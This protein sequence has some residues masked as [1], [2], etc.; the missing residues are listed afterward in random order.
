MAVQIQSLASDVPSLNLMVYADSGAGKTVF[1]GSAKR[2]LFVA[3]EDD[4][5]LS[6]VRMGSQA[7]KIKVRTWEDF[8]EGYEYCYDNQDEL[9]E[10][11][12]W[13][14]I[15][16][17][18]EMQ[19]MCLRSIVNSQRAERIS[20]DQDPDQPQIQDYGKLYILMEKMILAFNDLPINVLWTA[21]ARKAEDPDGNDFLL[22]MLG[23]NKPTDYRI[24]MKVAAQMTSYGY[25][26]V[27]VVDKPAPTDDDPK[28]TRKVKQRTI[29][30]EDTGSTRGKDRTTRLQPKTTLPARNALEYITGLAN[31]LIERD[32]TPVGKPASDV[33]APRKAAKKAAPQPKVD[34]K[35]TNG[36]ETGDEPK[37]V[38]LAS[39]EA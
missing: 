30:W 33:N 34:E 23:S 13:I 17:A 26:K 28:R 37:S 35:K 15:D 11:Y 22:P 25:L 16:S 31:G 36:E 1:A 27:E 10:K 3:P 38:D 6:A 39:V 7:D 20:K 4:G 12:D 18:T 2:V 8:V 9:K 32:G 24:A 5:T 19:S 14:V 29:I 21:L